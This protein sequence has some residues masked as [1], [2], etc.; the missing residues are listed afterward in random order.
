MQNHESMETRK[1]IGIV[2]LIVSLLT[3]GIFITQT[4]FSIQL[5]DWISYDYYMQFAPYVISIMLFYSGLYLIRKH[6][7]SNL[8]MAIF[9]YTIF[10]LLL[11]DLTGVSA[12]NW[13]T[14]TIVLFGCCAVMALWIAHANSFSLKRLSLSEI[15]LSIFLGAIEST[16]LYF[17]NSMSSSQT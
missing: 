14:V 10:E 7:K 11:L 16:V 8:A 9:G 5:Q 13:S 1:I 6:P 2:F 17:L 4:E 12:N 3:I 15:L